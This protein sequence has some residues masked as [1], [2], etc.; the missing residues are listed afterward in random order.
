[1]KAQIYV[2]YDR[3]AMESG[4]IFEARNDGV[5]FRQ[6]SAVV[7]RAKGANAE[8]YQLLKLGEIDHDTNVISPCDAEEIYIGLQLIDQEEENSAVQ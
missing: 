4:P 3:V 8:E 1:M 7:Q 5:A 6:Y 2:I